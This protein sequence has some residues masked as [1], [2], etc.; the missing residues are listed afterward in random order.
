MRIVTTRLLHAPE[1]RVTNQS[2]NYKTLAFGFSEMSQW[3]FMR[4]GEPRENH[5]CSN[6]RPRYPQ[7]DQERTRSTTTKDL[8]TSRG[9]KREPVSAQH[10]DERTIMIITMSSF[11][12]GPGGSRVLG[13]RGA[14]TRTGYKTFCALSHGCLTCR[15]HWYFIPTQGSLIR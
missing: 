9:L 11:S 5:N 7:G 6:T 10:I 8:G 14:C 4:S 3:L 2:I 12:L 15:A 13:S 1:Y